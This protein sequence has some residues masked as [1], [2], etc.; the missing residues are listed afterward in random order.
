M[1]LRDA[2]RNLIEQSRDV[3]KRL[4]TTEEETVSRA[5]LHI[6]EVQIYLLDK[7]IEKVKAKKPRKPLPPAYPPFEPGSRS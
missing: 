7:Q 6:L 4:D 3:M 2:V 5:D 1:D